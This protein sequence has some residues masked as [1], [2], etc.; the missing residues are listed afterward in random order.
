[1]VAA[2]PANEC[3]GASV[4]RLSA[5]LLFPWQITLPQ[6][7]MQPQSVM[8]QNMLPLAVNMLPL[9]VYCPL[10]FFPLQSVPLIHR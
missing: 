8:P 7:I 9:A 10:P 5:L 4:R 6:A 1:M 3:A 2:V